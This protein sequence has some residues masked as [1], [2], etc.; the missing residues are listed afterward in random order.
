MKSCNDL[1]YKIEVNI[2]NLVLFFVDFIYLSSAFWLLSFSSFLIFL[3]FLST[4]HPSL[5]APFLDSGHLILVFDHFI[6][7]RAIYV[8]FDWGYP[9]GLV[10]AI[11]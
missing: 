5:L 4:L 2:L 10:R 11:L 7:T 6:L 3:L 9:S 8:T 1:V